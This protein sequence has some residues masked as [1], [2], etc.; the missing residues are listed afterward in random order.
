MVDLLFLFFWWFMI[1]TVA[2]AIWRGGRRMAMKKQP[3]DG[4]DHGEC[5]QF[6]EEHDKHRRLTGLLLSYKIPQRPQFCLRREGWFDVFGKATRLAIEPQAGDPRFDTSVYIDTSDREL[7]ALLRMRAE[8]RSALLNLMQRL[9]T[10]GAR[11]C[12]LSGEAGHVHL[13]L[14]V[15]QARDVDRLRGECTAWLAP[16]LQALR[17]LPASWSLVRGGPFAE[18]D[19]PRLMSFLL[20]TAGCCFA[21]TIAFLSPDRLSDPWALFRF[22][23]VPAVIATLMLLVWSVRSTAAVSNRHR[24]LLEWLLLAPIGAVLFSFAAIRS[25]N[26]GLDFAVPQGVAI[27]DFEV[28]QTR[29]R[30]GR[31]VY[32]VSFRSDHPMIDGYDSMVI[33]GDTYQ[34]LHA[35]RLRD[36]TSRATLLLHP[37]VFG[38]AWKEIVP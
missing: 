34:R 12:S 3:F 10:Q 4:E 22:S 5:Y 31:T 25:I 27:S 14:N 11:Y 38:F 18:L 21:L 23:L 29:Q 6:R 9:K 15:A 36:K 26:V 2:A 20:F 1:F 33:G 16:F 37:G 30:R 32:H 13:Y 7:I 8:L 24:A 19:K 28:Y 17:T 35:A